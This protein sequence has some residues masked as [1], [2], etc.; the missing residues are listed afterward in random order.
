MNKKALSTTT[1]S[2]QKSNKQKQKTKALIA[3]LGAATQLTLGGAGAG[4]E[5]SQYR[6]FNAQN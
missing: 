5:S 1:T 2:A 3:N 4:F 6:Y